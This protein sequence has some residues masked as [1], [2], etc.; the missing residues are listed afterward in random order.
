MSNNFPLIFDAYSGV[1]GCRSGIG[2]IDLRILRPDPK[3]GRIVGAFTKA[4][5]FSIPTLCRQQ[6]FE[7]SQNDPAPNREV[8]DS[9][10]FWN[11]RGSL[12]LL[13]DIGK[14]EDQWP[15]ALSSASRE[16]PTT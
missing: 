14:L 12:G 6:P 1:F 3:M 7:Y 10:A 13:S 2:F 9:K 11:P 8:D 16:A 5:C 4:A 15:L